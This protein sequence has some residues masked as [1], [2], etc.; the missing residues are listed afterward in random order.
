MQR[1]KLITLR[2]EDA[3]ILGERDK[4]L[5]RDGRPSNAVPDESEL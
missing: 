2:I 4:R 1:E 5:N 3:V